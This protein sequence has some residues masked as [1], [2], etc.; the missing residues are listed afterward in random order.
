M[1][2]AMIRPLSGRPRP[3]HLIASLALV[4]LVSLCWYA[5]QP[6][7]PNCVYFSGSPD[8]PA[9]SDQCPP[10]QMRWRTWT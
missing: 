8:E 10:S 6:V 2:T 7:H 9:T 1:I 5:T 4:L 3:G